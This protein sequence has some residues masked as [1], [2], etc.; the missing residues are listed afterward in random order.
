MRGQ[1]KKE[2]GREERSV[3]DSQQSKVDQKRPLFCAL[4]HE[5]GVVRKRVDLLFGYGGREEGNS[6]SFLGGRTKKVEKEEEEE[7]TFDAKK[8]RGKKEGLGRR[9][10]EESNN[11]KLRDA[12]GGGWQQKK[13]HAPIFLSPSP[14]PQTY[15]TVLH[16]FLLYPSFPPAPPP[17]KMGV[18]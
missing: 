12:E 18:Y 17:P 15:Y 7:A 16:G 3:K 6:S 1:T 14:L 11:K 8:E 2:E 4:L 9:G 13:A 10:E 5:R